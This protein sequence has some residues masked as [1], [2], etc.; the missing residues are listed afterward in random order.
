MMCLK[1]GLIILRCLIAAYIIH[2]R[3]CPS[4]CPLPLCCLCWNSFIF[5][6]VCHAARLIQCQRRCHPWAIVNYNSRW[7]WRLRLL[8]WEPEQW[9]TY[10]S[11]W[12][13]V[14]TTSNHEHHLGDLKAVPQVVHATQKWCRS[15]SRTINSPSWHGTFGFLILSPTCTPSNQA[16]C[17]A[18]FRLSEPL[19]W[20]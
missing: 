5:Q 2:T 6:C 9:K 14:C 10:R 20:K 3:L 12:I 4:T 19:V 8:S 11:V 18:Q 13:C 1:S 7:L 16:T 15:L 17:V